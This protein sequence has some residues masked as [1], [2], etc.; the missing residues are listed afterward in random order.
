M[1]RHVFRF[2]LKSFQETHTERDTYTH[3]HITVR[4]RGGIAFYIGS[5]KYSFSRSVP[6]RSI[7]FRFFSLPF[8]HFSYK[9]DSTAQLLAAR[10]IFS[11]KMFID[12]VNVIWTRL[13]EPYTVYILFSF[14]EIHWIQCAQHLEKAI[15][16]LVSILSVRFGSVRNHIKLSKC[17][18]IFAMSGANYG[19]YSLYLNL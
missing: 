14:A 7:P 15:E 12:R 9:I 11:T 2:S 4:E 17:N 18:I 5:I 6:F 10:I 1:F 13:D 3:A 19:V 16:L 8:F